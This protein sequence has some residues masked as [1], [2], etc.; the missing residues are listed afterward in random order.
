MKLSS[1]ILLKAAQLSPYGHWKIVALAANNDSALWDYAIPLKTVPGGTLRADLREPVYTQFL[2]HGCIP[3]QE[4]ADKLMKKLIQKGDTVFDIGA[5][6]GY[7]SIL[8]CSLVGDKGNVIAFEPSARSFQQLLRNTAFSKRIKS[9]NLAIS[10]TI[11][12]LPFRETDCLERS[13]LEAVKSPSKTIDV[14]TL[15]LD[16]ICAQY[17]PPDFIKIDVEGHEYAVFEGAQHLLGSDQRPLIYFEALGLDALK[18]C[19]EIIQ[20]LSGNSLKIYRLSNQ[21]KLLPWQH[22]AGLNDFLAVPPERR[23]QIHSSLQAP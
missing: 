1:R 12:E 3:H 5:N 9:L 6:I 16:N 23:H 13:S 15:C 21:A 4:A 11:G 17:G 20:Q 14:K 22:P 2:R 7:L 18:H 10:N 19:V 8:F